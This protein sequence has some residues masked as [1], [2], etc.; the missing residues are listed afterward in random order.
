MTEYVPYL[1]LMHL[2]SS[3][4]QNLSTQRYRARPRRS[5]RSQAS[6]QRLLYRRLDGERQSAIFATGHFDGM[7]DQRLQ[8]GSHKR[9]PFFDKSG[10]T[11]RNIGIDSH[12]SV[13]CPIPIR[14]RNSR[15]RSSGGQLGYNYLS[16]T[17]WRITSCYG[18]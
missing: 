18:E 2:A 15:G 12:P 13:S 10:Q 11:Y 17:P 3:T 16:R 1:F 14:C 4:V 9:V 5:Y 8:I 6:S 7:T